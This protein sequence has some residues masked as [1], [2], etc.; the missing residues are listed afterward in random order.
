MRNRSIWKMLL[1]AILIAMVVGCATVPPP[2]EMIEH[3]DHA[4]LAA[5]YQQEAVHLRAK[6]EEMKE[7]AK[8]YE[9]R[10]TKPRQSSALIQHCRNLADRYTTAASEA[11]AAAKLH[12]EQQKGQ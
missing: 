8:S 7:M 3:K 11:E 2:Q 10:M 1:G 4:G 5:W 9:E 12:A 6:A